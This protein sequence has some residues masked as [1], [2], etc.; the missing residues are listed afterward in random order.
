MSSGGW[1]AFRDGCVLLGPDGRPVDAAPDFF[2][3]GGVP[4][5]AAVLGATVHGMAG[6]LLAKNG[7]DGVLASEIAHTLRKVIH[8]LRS[9]NA[10]A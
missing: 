9:G 4:F 10:K 8:D 1:W 6:D 2:K 7:T 5:D 3:A